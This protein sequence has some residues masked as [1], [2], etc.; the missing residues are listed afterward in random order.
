M[1]VLCEWIAS[2]FVVVYSWATYFPLLLCLQDLQD[3]I[4]SQQAAVAGLN[5]TG[6]E[7]IGQSSAADGFILKEKLSK[8]NRRWQE[9]CRQVDE[10]K[11]R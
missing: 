3:G 11:R 6:E 4:G 8:L 10:R 2:L 9:I 1:V 5:V 7:I